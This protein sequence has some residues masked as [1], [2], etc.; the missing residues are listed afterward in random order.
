MNNIVASIGYIGREQASEL[1]PFI[2]SYDNM[3]TLAN[4]SQWLGGLREIFVCCQNSKT[5][6]P[7]F[8]KLFHVISAVKAALDYECESAQAARGGFCSVQEM[9]GMPKSLAVTRPRKPEPRS[10][11]GGNSRARPRR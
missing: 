9:L 2:D 3:E 5:E 4:V 6:L 8:G 10:P 7:D 1:N 11:S